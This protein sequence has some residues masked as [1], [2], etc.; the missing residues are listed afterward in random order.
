MTFHG[1]LSTTRPERRLVLQRAKHFFLSVRR[2]CQRKSRIWLVCQLVATT[3]TITIMV[4]SALG[5]FSTLV[6]P[7]S[8]PQST[9]R[10]VR[11]LANSI[12]IPHKGWTAI[13]Q[14]AARR[15]ADCLECADGADYAVAERRSSPFSFFVS[16]REKRGR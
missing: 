5:T 13:S 1:D 16:T 3:S 12:G 2:S 7:A 9:A 4:S 11:N 8:C 6:H 14:N 10:W 15:H